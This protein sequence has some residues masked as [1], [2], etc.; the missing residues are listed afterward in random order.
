MRQ[1]IERGELSFGTLEWGDADDPLVL[2]LHGYPDTAWTW[3]RTLPVLAA[4]GFR[5]APRS[6][7]ASTTS[8]AASKPPVFAP[9]L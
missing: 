5:A 4:R 2:C 8:A 6:P 9:A 3:D 7:W 1:R